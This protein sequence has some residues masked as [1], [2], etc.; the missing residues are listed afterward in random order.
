MM[1]TI[2]SVYL[3]VLSEEGESSSPTCRE[4]RFLQYVSPKT[5]NT[6]L[7]LSWAIPLHWRVFHAPNNPGRKEKHH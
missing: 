4:D 3:F 2:A 7:T 6:C 1:P 5:C